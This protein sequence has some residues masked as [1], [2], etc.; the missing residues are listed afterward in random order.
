[1]RVRAA[2]TTSSTEL[3]ELPAGVE[4]LI[5]CQK[6]GRRVEVPPYVND[7]WAHLPLYGGCITN[8]HVR[9]PDDRL[10]DV[11]LC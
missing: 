1:M 2:A 11:P 5:R 10:P 4:V 8:I 9:S 6:Q 3:T 7:W